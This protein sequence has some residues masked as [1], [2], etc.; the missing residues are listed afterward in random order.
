M[1][2]L[3]LVLHFLHWCYSITA[4]L[5]ANQNRVTFSCMLLSLKFSVDS[6]SRIHFHT[7]PS[8]RFSEVSHH[9]H[10]RSQ[11][12]PFILYDSNRSVARNFGGGGGG[13]GRCEL[14]LWRTLAITLQR[15]GER[16]GGGYY[17]ND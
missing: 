13:G 16:E 12:R 10:I 2:L 5:S 7:M 1:T 14:I 9:Q 8:G 4:L 17:I 6:Y 11:S 15:K 3:A